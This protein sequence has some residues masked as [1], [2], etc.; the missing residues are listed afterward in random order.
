MADPRKRYSREDWIETAKSILV[1]SGVDGVKVDVIAKRM[2]ITRGSFYWHFDKRQ[3]LL[4]ALLK[5]WEDRNRAAL[6]SIR[7]AW[8]DGSPDVVDIIELWMGLG[9]DV[10]SFNM[11]TRLW[12][13]QD[14]RVNAAIRKVDEDWLDLLEEM[15]Q[16]RGLEGMEAKA[17]ARILYFHQM[18]YYTLD[19]RET[20]E[21]RL[22]MLPYYDEIMFGT[23]SQID[24]SALQEPE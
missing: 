1:R 23:D 16:F 22:A 10:L 13:R 11:S 2:K 24:Y 20:R 6:E 7:K 14:D 21:E 5:D 9:D 12:G 15:Y 8:A 18:G 19:L 4:D 3:D 17:R